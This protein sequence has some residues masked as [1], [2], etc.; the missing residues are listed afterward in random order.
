MLGTCILAYAVV[1]GSLQQYC[2]QLILLTMDPQQQKAT[3]DIKDDSPAAPDIM[4]SDNP[5]V[6]SIRGPDTLASAVQQEKA[7]PDDRT[8][9][10]F[11][12]PPQKE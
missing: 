2:Q 11:V 7:Q 5:E 6:Q 1:T 10:K 12:D 8:T 9:T 4:N 3:Q